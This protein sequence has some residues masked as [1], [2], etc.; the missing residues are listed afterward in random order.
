MNM[1]D[2]IE[3]EIA[4]ENS[5]LKEIW[6]TNRYKMIRAGVFENSS[7]I[8]AIT[9][10]N[11]V[12]RICNY[13]FSGCK[14]LTT[15]N[16]PESLCFIGCGAFQGCTKLESITFPPNLVEISNNAFWNCCNLT[17]ISLPDSLRSIGYSAFRGCSKLE[18]ITIPQNV[19]K[20]SGSAFF[21]CRNL[22]S[23]TVL[24]SFLPYFSGCYF[25]SSITIGKNLQE[26]DDEAFLECKHIKSIV[27][28]ENNPFYDSRNNCNALIETGSDTLLLACNS[29]K[30]PEGIKHISERAFSDCGRIK[31]LSLPSSL[32][33]IKRLPE[34][35]KKI[36]VPKGHKREFKKKLPWTKGI[37]IIEK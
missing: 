23:V 4:I 32:E 13:A 6:V 9:V 36:I 15:V 37:E 29:T 18:A 8:A 20:V 1:K 35:V 5:N 17:S 10:P 27:V 33:T 28:D 24:G 30:I 19:E 16:L 31:T 34:N 21:N 12:K 11:P 25:I 22:K 3:K 2:Y 7:K 26:F 14:E